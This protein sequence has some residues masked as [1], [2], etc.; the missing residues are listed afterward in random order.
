[1]PKRYWA[2]KQDLYSGKCFIALKITIHSAFAIG[3]LIA[4]RAHESSGTCLR[5]MKMRRAEALLESIET[6]IP[7]E[8][9]PKI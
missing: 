4:V 1:V 9:I 2:Y 3:L 8:S 7:E 6:M 5:I